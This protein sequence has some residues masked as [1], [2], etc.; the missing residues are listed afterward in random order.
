MKVHGQSREAHVGT[1]FL[2][3]AVFLGT[4]LHLQLHCY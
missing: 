4:T 1:P 2:A 3:A